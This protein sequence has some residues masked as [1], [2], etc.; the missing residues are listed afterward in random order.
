[1]TSE[2]MP[3]ITREEFCE[4]FKAQMLKRAGQPEFDDGGSIAEYADE[5][6]STY[7]DDPDQRFWGPEECADADMSYWGDE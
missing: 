3:E 4:R 7:F 5:A 6:G 2:K 1:M